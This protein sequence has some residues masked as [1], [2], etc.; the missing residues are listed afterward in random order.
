MRIKQKAEK[1]A[2]SVA[3]SLLIIGIFI[4]HPSVMGSDF[5]ST[6][7]RYAE[8]FPH[9]LGTDS[10]SLFLEK[11]MNEAEGLVGLSDVMFYLEGIAAGRVYRRGS[12]TEEDIYRLRDFN[13]LRTQF[14]VSDRNTRLLPEDV[15]VDAFAQM[16]LT[17][18]V[19]TPGPKVLIFHTHTTE[20]FADSRPDT[21]M[22][23]V[24][25][26]GARLSEVL[27]Q[28]YGIE[29]I[30]DVTRYDIVNGR[31]QITGA[32]ERMEP[33]IRQILRDNPTIEIVIDLHRDGLP[34][35]TPPLVSYI[36]GKRAA[37]IMF[38]N[39]LSRRYNSSGVLEPVQWLPNPYLRD[40]LAFSFQLQ[41][42]ANR[43]YPGFA[44]RV[45]LK[46]FRYSLHLMPRTILLEVGAQN[47]T[48]A[49]AHNAVPHIAS[50]I[51]DVILP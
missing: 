19:S 10:S 16:D 7:H 24:L 12:I 49:E 9:A 18:D 38:V 2:R 32:Y 15:D 25:G 50:I 5:I 13:Y 8:Y 4:S 45:Y 39:G 48:M 31:P 30:H 47:N 28:R 42:A 1:I 29:T 26:V 33:Y 23:G 46:A 40:N 43:L 22:D 36:N 37:R 3:I 21:P 6:I 51:A 11:H 41:F 20:M 17:I 44:R 34:E 27:E 14:Y 35:G